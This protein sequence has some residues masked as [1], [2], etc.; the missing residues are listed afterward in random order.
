MSLMTK[1]ST[2]EQAGG[3]MSRHE[4]EGGVVRGVGARAARQVPRGYAAAARC[5]C[6]RQRA[7]QRRAARGSSAARARRAAAAARGRWRRRGQVR[8]GVGKGVR[9]DKVRGAA[10]A[11]ARGAMSMAHDMSLYN[12]CGAG[13]PEPNGGDARAAPLMLKKIT[14][15]L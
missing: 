2:D 14:H 8:R 15:S 9:G 10:K 3:G 4:N 12:R 7:G 1:M 5:A 11:A 6:A 13:R